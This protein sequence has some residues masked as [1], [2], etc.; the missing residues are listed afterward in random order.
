MELQNIK[1]AI[2]KELL[3]VDFEC[4][5]ID[6][7]E[8]ISHTAVSVIDLMNQ[9]IQTTI[10]NAL[11]YCGDEAEPELKMTFSVNSKFA[12]DPAKVLVKMTSNFSIKDAVE[13]SFNNDTNQL[14]IVFGN[15]NE[16]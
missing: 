5:S 3:G 1:E 9:H 16:E 12:Q 15:D 4:G 14:E 7:S 13:S 2:D 10:K 8:I 11:Q 6:V